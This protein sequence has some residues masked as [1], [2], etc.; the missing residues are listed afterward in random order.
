[1]NALETKRSEIATALAVVLPDGRFS[2]Y[3]RPMTRAVAPAGW[4]EQP[5]GG[6]QTVAGG[7]AK[8]IVTTFPIWFVYDGTDEAQVAGLDDLIT[9]AWTALAALP[10]IHPRRWRPATLPVITQANGET[11]TIPWRAVVI[12]VEA[13]ILAVSFCALPA[14]EPVD[15]PPDI[16]YS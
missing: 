10:H 15:I 8:Q 12:D 7:N 3:P 11:V 1:M 13:V 2:A 14:A 6:E 5:F 9:K 4:V 16:V